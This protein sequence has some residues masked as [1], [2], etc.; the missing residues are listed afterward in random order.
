MMS[1]KVCRPFVSPATVYLPRNKLWSR[2]RTW[3]TFLCRHTALSALLKSLQP[4]SFSG[5]GQVWNLNRLYLMNGKFPTSPMNWVTWVMYIR[6]PGQD[7][8]EVS[9]LQAAEGKQPAVRSKH[10]SKYLNVGEE[11]ISGLTTNRSCAPFRDA[12]GDLLGNGT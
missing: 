4:T 8:A 1:H 6:A 10:D 3:L 5:M 9:R 12:R 11:S 7:A 2:V